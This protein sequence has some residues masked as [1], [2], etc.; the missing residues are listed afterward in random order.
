[1]PHVVRRERGTSLGQSLETSL[2]SGSRESSWNGH[3][4]RGHL[5]GIVPPQRRGAKEILVVPLLSPW[6]PSPS[7]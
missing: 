7:A 4:E 2:C 3:L 5:E 6:T 1:M